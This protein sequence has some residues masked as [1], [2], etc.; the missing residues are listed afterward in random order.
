MPLT[1]TKQYKS[2]VS[3]LTITV[4]MVVSGVFISYAFFSYQEQHQQMVQEIRGQSMESA[5]R[6]SS[7][8]APY[9]EAYEVN[10]YEKLLQT[11]I[12]TENHYALEAL[13]IE[14]Y[15]MGELLGETAYVTGRLRGDA[16]EVREYEPENPSDLGVIANAFSDTYAEIY[17]S[18]GELMGRITVYVNDGL[19]K[20]RQESLLWQTT[21][22]TLVLLVILTT[23][24]VVLLKRF[25]IAPLQAIAKTMSVRDEDGIPTS[26]IPPSD[27]REVAVLSDM[28][29]DMLRVI[30]S[31]QERV[32]LE[33][34]RL[35]NVIKGTRAGTWYWN[36]QSGETVFNDRWAEML[37]YRLEE[38]E[39]ISIE[40][41]TGLVHPDDLKQSEKLLQAYF[42]GEV[43]FYECEAR[44]RHRDGHWIWVLDRG[45]VATWSDEG[46]PLEMYGTHQDITEEKHYEE[47][48]AL[49]ASV[50]KQVHEGILITNDRGLI[51][52]VNDAFTRIT[53]YTREEAVGRSPN[54]LKSG[55]HDSEFYA[56]L[57]RALQS[58]GYWSGELWN[59]R[60]NGDVYPELITISAVNSETAGETHFVALFS[61]ITSIKEHE[62]QL[63]QI[64]HYDTLTGLPNRLLFR[65]RLRQSMSR[66]SRHKR[67]LALLFLDLDGFKEVNDSYGHDVGD[68]LLIILAERT[69]GLLRDEDT[70]ARLGGDE[71][72][73]ILPD[74]ED[75]G[76]VSPVL[77]RLLDSTTQPIKVGPLELTVSASIG[78]ALYPDHEDMD[79]DQLIRQAD[80]AMYNAKLAGKNCYHFF[81]PEQD[82]SLRGINEL[83]LRIE[84]GLEAAEFELY[85]QP[86][87]NL[88][89]REVVGVEGL[90]RW[91]RGDEGILPPAEFLPMIQDHRLLV[92]LGEWTIEEA[93]RQQ[94]VWQKQGLYLPVSINTA[95]IHL[96]QDNFVSHLQQ[97]LARYPDVAPQQIEFEVLESSALDNLE[98]VQRVIR[99]CE[100]LGIGFS[101]DDFGTGYSTL[102]Y[103]KHLPAQ[104]LKI[105]RSFVRNMRDETDD[106]L[107][108][109]AVIGLARAFRKQVIAEGLEDMQH[110][111][112]LLS[113]GCE[114]AQGYGIAR[115]MPAAE[116]PDWLVRWERAAPEQICND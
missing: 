56:A 86:K 24:L 51:V 112:I 102:A 54:I 38:L 76:G 74:I 49:S 37:G 48:L 101:I 94:Q 109:D 6:L 58:K 83:I 59:R 85:Y 16:G 87:V 111:D 55:H 90:I 47:Q 116:L 42:A 88:R 78:V 98:Q 31:T 35:D 12:Q 104:T 79:A 82:R 41:W 92:R 52:D 21:L 44:M 11:E 100:A 103:L 97:I 25:L 8:V 113:I 46:E 19:L 108:L 95:A 45:K 2:L 80:Q 40:T 69:S 3:Q 75:Q 63:E 15:R 96:Q 110:A 72:I 89:T 27:Y 106:R 9:M 62:R 1:H 36:I 7:I 84:S 91:N 17:A 93:L 34:D 32:K 107:I 73:I 43:D 22:T 61:D 14:D 4:L 65:D 28:V 114:L 60:K 105:D 67:P 20:H 13:V 70:L 39:P 115:P 99:Q 18:N 81:D 30:R 71:F 26:P 33:H 10:E 77:Q 57:W 5:E 64:A 50:Y 53:G 68:E 23:L 29:N 66:A